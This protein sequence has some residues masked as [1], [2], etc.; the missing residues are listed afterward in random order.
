MLSCFPLGPSS[1]ASSKPSPTTVWGRLPGRAGIRPLPGPG[2][3]DGENFGGFY[4]SLMLPA[5]RGVCSCW[6]MSHVCECMF[7]CPSSS[8]DW[9]TRAVYTSGQKAGL[10]GSGWQIWT[11][12]RCG[13]K[14]A[15]QSKALKWDWLSGPRLLSLHPLMASVTPTPRSALVDWRPL[16]APRPRPGSAR[17]WQ[18]GTLSSSGFCSP[19][20]AL[21]ALKCHS[22][23]P[24][25]CTF[26]TSAQFLLKPPTSF[27][28][29]LAFPSGILFLVSFCSVLAPCPSLC[30]SFS[31]AFPLFGPL[32]SP[33]P[34]CLHKCVCVHTCV[35]QR[36]LCL[37]IRALRG[38]AP[39]AR[40][41]PES[42]INSQ[43]TACF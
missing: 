4:L 32:S 30:P 38:V 11:L 40:R 21:K 16:A 18:H 1:A 9:G 7:C 28:Q 5:W 42:H 24:Q 19:G 13:T 25:L 12:P 31:F 22:P 15:P 6:L 36:G 17:G 27:L 3:G 8:R 14:W 33:S 41:S 37:F 26:S 10:R 34:A 20:T 43:L 39:A 2:L 23:R 35:L 29:L